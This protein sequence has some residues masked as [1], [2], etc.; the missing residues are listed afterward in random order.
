MDSFTKYPVVLVH[1]LAAKDFPFCRAFGGIANALRKHNVITYVTDQDGVGTIPNN[2]KQLKNQIEAFCKAQGCEKVNIIAHSKGG[3][4]AR[5][6]ISA[7][8]MSSRVASLTTLSTPHHGSKLSA[9]LLR[10]PRWLIGHICFFINKFY[11]IFRDECPDILSA[12]K[13]LTDTAMQ[14]FN[15]VILNAPGVYYQSYSSQTSKANA[16]LVFI[17]YQIS[18]YCEQDETDGLVSVRSSQWGDYKG[19]IQ[20]NLNHLQI[21]DLYGSKRKRQNVAV[22][23]MHIITQLREMGF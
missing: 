22:F 6:M 16:F 1:G 4:D 21:I 19:Q 18:R 20:G 17:P 23:Y 7:L 11:W 12:A 15:T 14:D 3:L 5:Y 2:A 13:E 9:A 8:D 10:Y